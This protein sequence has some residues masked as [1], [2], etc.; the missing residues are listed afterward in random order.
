MPQGSPGADELDVQDVEARVGP[1]TL[2]SS[3]CNAARDESLS[4]SRRAATLCWLRSFVD[5]ED[6]ADTFPR[7]QRRRGGQIP[8]R[9]EKKKTVPKR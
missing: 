9:R 6:A 1:T 2:T 8:G 3:S 4:T 7:Q 5:G